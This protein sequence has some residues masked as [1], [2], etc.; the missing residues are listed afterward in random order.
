[1]INVLHLL[2]IAPLSASFGAFVMAL[3]AGVKD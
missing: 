3:F 2:W 1:M